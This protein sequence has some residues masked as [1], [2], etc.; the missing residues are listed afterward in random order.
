MTTTTKE[1]DR[2]NRPE[3]RE[4]VLPQSFDELRALI[5]NR[6]PSFSKQLQKIAR[7]T[8]EYPNELALD[9]VAS[10]ARRASVPPSS[11][12]RFAQ[13]LGYDG[14][15]EMQQVFRTHLVD[16]S[17]SYKER[18]ESLRKEHA[19]A[20]GGAGSILADF[21]EEGIQSLQLLRDETQI[22]D[23]QQAA[24]LLAG[25]DDIFVVAQRRAY[26]V[27][28]YLSYALGRL[29]RPAYLLDGAGGVLE[30]QA[31]LATTGDVLLAISF[32]PYSPDVADLVAERA[33]AGVD[34]IAV[35]DSAVSPIALESVIAFSIRQQEERAFRSL[36][37]PMCLAQ[38]LVVTL[39]NLIANGEE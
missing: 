25:A 5:A 38:T 11:L 28:F 19:S 33:A 29:D 27:A 1:L 24:R 13:A 10:V 31:K 12:V 39:G 3:N 21:T 7:F 14:Y 9:T 23:L 17:Q 35:T 32:P 30:Q 34:V 36:V 20:V 16:R 22:R 6:Y 4:P 37:A 2:K 26:P 18:I 15:T 8:L